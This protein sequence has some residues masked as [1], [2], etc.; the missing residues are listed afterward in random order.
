MDCCTQ[1]V[2]QSGHGGVSESNLSALG[3]RWVG[4]ELGSDSL[5]GH[6]EPQ[7]PGTPSKGPNSV[8]LGVGRTN[9]WAQV[10]GKDAASGEGTEHLV[11]NRMLL[12]C[13][14]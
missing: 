10:G 7:I 13:R 5:G 8:C 9:S 3:G 1:R 14:V 11:L 2:L 12:L 4:W 6:V